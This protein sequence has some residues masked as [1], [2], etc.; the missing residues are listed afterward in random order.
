MTCS[1]PRFT[2]ARSTGAS[3]MKFGRAPTT[4]RT[5]IRSSVQVS[6]DQDRG[7][8]SREDPDDPERGFAVVPLG[9][10]D[11]IAGAQSHPLALRAPRDRLLQVTPPHAVA[12]DPI[13]AS[14]GE[15]RVLC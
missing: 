10:D 4:E 5:R 13:D 2:S 3:F 15:L 7:G 11:L 12:A 8:N 9:H 6:G 14:A 1:T